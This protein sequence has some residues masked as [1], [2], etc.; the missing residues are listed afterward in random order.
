MKPI[1]IFFISVCAFAAAPANDIKVDQVGYLPHGAKVAMVA[2]STLAK[3]FSVK[4]SGKDSVAFHGKLAEPVT[5]PDSGDLVQ[6]LDFSKL[7]KPGKYYIEVPGVGRS[8]DFSIDGNVFSNAFYLTM[9][10]YY[11]Q[12]CGTAVDLGPKFPGYKHAACHLQG[13]YHASSGKTG[14]H[15]SAKGWHDA[16]DYGRYVVNSG[17]STGTLLWAWELYGD[18]LKQVKLDIPESGN[19]TPDI[20][21]EIRWNLDWML[22]MQDEDGGA[23]QKQTSDRFCN[24]IMPEKDALVSDVIGTG[25]EPYKSSCATG[26]FAAVMAIA[27]RAYRPFDAAYADKCLRVA[28]QAWDWLEKHPDVLFHNPAGV[29]TGDYGDG[30]CADEHLW[31]SAELA[32]TTGD[33]AFDRY[34]L[35]HFTPFRKTIRAVGPPSWAD[36]APLALWTYALGHGKNAD[37]VAAITQDSVSAAQQIVER[38]ARHPYRISL[39]PADYIWGSNGV[40]ANYSMQLMVANALHPDT[41]FVDAALDNLHYLLGRNTFSLSWVT[42]LGEN[43][44]R[45]PHHR[46]SGASG[47]PEPWPGLL[48]GG[49]N[50]GRQ[51][52]AMKKLPNGPPAKM[53]LDELASYASNEVAINWNAPLVLVLAGALR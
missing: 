10:S 39:T 38:T 9:R 2:S 17:I 53:Y 42:Q 25:A 6:I 48:S 47:L 52:A 36:V 19:G 3:E 24:F 50:R 46:P 41:S 49:P 4:R 35:D 18:R 1:A 12:R 5:D 7:D 26:D 33:A 16:G 28:R 20:L 11:G 29:S 37:A 45:H 44:F 43:P 23:W 13:A 32:R 31:A 22:S 27:A 8:W 51:D 30:N 34:F 40:A 14:P 15:V 21:N